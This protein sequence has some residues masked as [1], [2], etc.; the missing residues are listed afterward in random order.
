MIIVGSLFALITAVFLLWPL[1]RSGPA[2]PDRAEAAMAIFKDQLS[3]VDRDAARNLISDTEAQAARVEI[4]RRMLSVS[5]G[6]THEMKSSGGWALI[7]FAVLVPLGGIGVYS[8]TG[9]PGM[10]SVTFAERAQE[11]EEANEVAT[12]INRLRTRLEEDPDGGDVRGWELLASTYMGRNL[13][14]DAAYAYSQIVDRPDATSATWSQYA[15]A[16]IADENGAVTPLAARA[17]ARAMQLDPTNPA[18]TFYSALERE[19]SGQTA[20]A[21]RMLLDRVSA[22]TTPL[23]WMPAFIAEANRMARSI[24]LEE[25]ALPSFSDTPRGPSQEDID[26]AGEMSPEDQA[27]FIASMVGNLEA[28]LEADPSDLQG[29]LQLARAY[30]VLERPE[31]AVAALKSAQPLASELAVEDPLRRAVEESLQQLGG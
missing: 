30:V 31:D 21:R 2:A 13:F 4:K 20:L 15:E 14:K 11:V 9:S 8:V 25:E 17:I 3:E 29:W 1:L 7:A 24:G 27:E 19:Q 28:R 6:E 5:R 26:A 12:L 18:A 23:P 16:L 10:P 22:E